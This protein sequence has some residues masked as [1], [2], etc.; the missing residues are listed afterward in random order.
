VNITATGDA[1]KL[2]TALGARLLNGDLA[3]GPELRFVPPRSG[4]AF[5]SGFRRGPCWPS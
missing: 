2:A 4:K 3:L 1:Q 5:C